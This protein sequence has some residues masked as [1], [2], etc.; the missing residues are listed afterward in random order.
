MKGVFAICFI[1]GSFVFMRCDQPKPEI[2]NNK[3]LEVVEKFNQKCPMMID[4]ETRID[5]IEVKKP[6][7]IL[8]KYT[9]MNVSVENVDTTLFEAALRPGIVNTLK[10]NPDLKEMRDLKANFEYYYK[11]KKNKFIYSFTITPIDYKL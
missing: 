6:N 2:V 4:S 1:L 8:Y 7:T 3:A 5:G 9:L 10:T 11:D